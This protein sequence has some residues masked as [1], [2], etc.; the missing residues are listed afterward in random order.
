MRRLFATLSSLLLAVSLVLT[1]TACTCAIDS[2]HA[3]ETPTASTSTES[4]AA[5]GDEDCCD[6]SEHDDDSE[7]GCCGGTDC[8]LSA[9]QPTSGISPI[10]DLSQRDPTAEL[11][12][13]PSLLHTIP[14]A[15][16]LDILPPLEAMSPAPVSAGATP[17]FRADTPRYLAL[18]VLRL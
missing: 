11:P 7:E 8:A 15:W 3:S 17:D 2:A 13:A 12:E 16:T 6:D 14:A 18:Q 10:A 9:R 1:G 4:E 5:G